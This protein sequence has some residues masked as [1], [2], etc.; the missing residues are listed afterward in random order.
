MYEAEISRNNPTCFLFLIDQSR[1]MLEQLPTGVSKAV[2]VAESLNSVLSQLII[3]CSRS[4][5]TGDY[6]DV[7]VI[8]YGKH[9]NSRQNGVMNC[10]NTENILTPISIVDNSTIRLETRKKTITDK[11]GNKVEV[12][13]NFPIWVEP[14]A[15]G[16]TPMLAAFTVAANEVAHWIDKHPS[17][18]PPVILNITDGVATDA[19]NYE[20]LQ[21][22][23]IVREMS[24]EDGNVLLFNLHI[25][26]T[27]DDPIKLPNEL[28]S[29]DSFMNLLFDM[30]SELPD[31]MLEYAKTLG[32]NQLNK[33]ARG[34]MFNAKAE[35][36]ANFLQIGTKPA[37]SISNND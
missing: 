32:F 22:A 20:M 21:M 19:K 16:S 27:D 15:G 36:I 18:Y 28:Y 14:Q 23:N 24:T 31:T 4:Y 10:L 25:S 17:A 2:E 12:N 7:G 30:S 3:R 6:F 26:T 29:D 5:G 9:A 11:N 33:G 34:F 37:Q 35:D 13:A 1:S 8:G